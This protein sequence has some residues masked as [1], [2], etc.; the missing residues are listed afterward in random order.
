ML[1]GT[2]PEGSRGDAYTSSSYSFGGETAITTSIQSCVFLKRAG[3]HQ[4][5]AAINQRLELLFFFSPLRCSRL[6]PETSGPLL[7]RHQ[8]G[9]C[10][11]Q[12]WA[13]LQGRRRLQTSTS[14]LAHW[15]TF[16]HRHIHSWRRDDS[17]CSTQWPAL[18]LPS[19]PPPPP[20]P[21]R[22]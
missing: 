19:P 17:L 10:R 12:P 2:R 5:S 7:G 15:Q 18:S 4:D 13:R 22:H 16:S 6:E 8:S 9:S 3:R 11:W 14:E 1:S 20:L 21:C